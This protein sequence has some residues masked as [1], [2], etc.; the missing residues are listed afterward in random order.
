MERELRAAEKAARQAEV[1]ERKED[2]QRRTEH[3]DARV[4]S[5][6]SVLAEGLRF[7]A[8]LYIDGLRRGPEITPLDLGDLAEPIVATAWELAEPSRPG[9]VSRAFGGMRQWCERRDVARRRYDNMT[10][11]SQ[12][13]NAVSAPVKLRSSYG[14]AST[15]TECGVRSRWRVSA[16]QRS[17]RCATASRN[18]RRAPLRRSCGTCTTFN[19]E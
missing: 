19:M 17:I 15:R 2:A 16:M 11:T 7:P 5:L 18:G 14:N 9:T 13:S 8:A 12:M 1:V 6:R 3:L 10:T 4:S